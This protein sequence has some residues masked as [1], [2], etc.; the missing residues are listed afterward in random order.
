MRPVASMTLAM[1]SRWRIVMKSSRPY[2]LRSGIA[3]VKTIA[4]PVPRRS[5]PTHRKHAVNNFHGLL[6]GAIA[7]SCQIRDQTDE[8]EHQRNRAVGRNRKHVPDQWAA[9]LRPNSHGAG[10][11]HHVKRHPRSAGVNEREHTRASHGE[12]RHGFRKTVDGGAPLLIQQKQNRG[13]ERA[14]VADTD[15]PDEIDDSK[16]PADGDVDAPDAGAFDDQPADGDGHHAHEAEGNQKSDVPA[17]RGWTRQNNCTDLVRD[18]AVGVPRAD[19]RRQAADFGRIE[20]WLPGA[21]ADSNSGFGL[22]TAA[23]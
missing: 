6:D 19:H 5:A 3:M 18:R 14:G 15:P 13:D 22:R 12:K 7:Q 10:V 9:E 2:A 8:P 17:E 21:H 20:R 4:K 1:L 23:R 16:S 11:R